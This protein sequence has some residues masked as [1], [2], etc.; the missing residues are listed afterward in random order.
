LAPSQLLRLSNQ[1]SMR[2]VL[3]VKFRCAKN[4]VSRLSENVASEGYAGQKQAKKRSLRVVN[5]HF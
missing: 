5:E 1:C 3:V 2:N 4:A